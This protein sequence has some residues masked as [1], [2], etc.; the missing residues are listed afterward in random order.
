[1]DTQEYNERIDEIDTIEGVA[2]FAGDEKF[3]IHLQNAQT[4]AISSIATA[5][6]L[7]SDILPTAD[8]G[9][10]ISAKLSDINTALS[11]FNGKTLSSQTIHLP[12]F[13]LI[14]ML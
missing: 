12:Q 11:S 6:E 14:L 8:Q 1:M 13:L 5:M 3:I 7:Y 4:D 2:I 10:I 9:I